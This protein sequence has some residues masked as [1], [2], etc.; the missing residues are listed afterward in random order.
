M[1]CDSPVK[2]KMME[3]KAGESVFRQKFWTLRALAV[4]AVIVTGLFACFRVIRATVA[5]GGIAGILSS[6]GEVRREEQVRRHPSHDELIE[7]TVRDVCRLVTLETEARVDVSIMA[8]RGSDL[9]RFLGVDAETRVD[10]TVPVVIRTG[11]ELGNTIPEYSL[12]DGI[13]R[14]T[15]DRARVFGWRIVPE[16]TSIVRNEVNRP[17]FYDVYLLHTDLVTSIHDSV[18]VRLNPQLENAVLEAMTRTQNLLRER[19]TQMGIA[20]SVVVNWR[21]Y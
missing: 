19:I 2:E 16:E 5:I 8:S 4:G 21:E 17:L 10:L 1:V 7:C 9:A 20:E 12:S 13:L 11:V 14:I 3:S 6:A 15:L 18:S